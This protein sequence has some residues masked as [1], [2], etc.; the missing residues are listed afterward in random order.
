MIIHDHNEHSFPLIMIDLKVLF[1]QKHSAFNLILQSLEF[2]QLRSC[3][4]LLEF[5]LILEVMMSTLPEKRPRD[6]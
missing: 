4:C 2:D 6:S 1:A 3:W 5:E